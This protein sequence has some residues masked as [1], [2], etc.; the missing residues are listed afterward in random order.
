MRSLT[1][2]ISNIPRSVTKNRFGDILN[3]VAGAASISSG[4]PDQPRL[5]GW[6]FTPAAASALSERFYV[7]TVSL[8]GPPAPIQL[9]AAIKHEIG[10][11]ASHL[12]VDLDFFGLTPLADPQQD[13]DVEQVLS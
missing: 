5:L 11:K 10:D 4:A 9:E 6:S 12:R 1:F 7:A 13:V 3:I 8:R 2:R